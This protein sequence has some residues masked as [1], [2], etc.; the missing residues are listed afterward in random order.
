MGLGT[1]AYDCLNC[2]SAAM[3]FFCL[4]SSEP[5][6]KKAVARATSDAEGAGAATGCGE[7]LGCASAGLPATST[8]AARSAATAA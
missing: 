3:Y 6:W 8:G 2:S 7:G 1:A 4:R 5:F